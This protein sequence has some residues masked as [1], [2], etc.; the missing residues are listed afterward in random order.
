MTILF[1]VNEKDRQFNFSTA[2]TN[3]RFSNNRDV[4]LE[5][6]A[7]NDARLLYYLYQR[8]SHQHQHQK[9]FFVSDAEK[10]TYGTVY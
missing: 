7:G 8:I 6:R 5:R 2:G 4:S 3:K 10:C 1:M 9:S